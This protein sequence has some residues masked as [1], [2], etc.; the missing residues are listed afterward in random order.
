MDKNKII[1][2]NINS[3]IQVLFVGRLE[4]YK[5]IETFFKAM[6]KVLESTKI[7]IKI[8]IVGDGNLFQKFVRICKKSAYYEK[9]KL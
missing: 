5:G 2:K 8:L 9:F 1:K 3:R 7:N 4:E 6:I